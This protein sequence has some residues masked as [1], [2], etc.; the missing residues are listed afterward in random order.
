MRDPPAEPA[1]AARADAVPAAVGAGAGARAASLSEAEPDVEA[2]VW[3]A[4]DAVTRLFATHYRQLVR[5][6]TLLLHDRAV[7]EEVTQD[8]YV[9]LHTSWRRLRDSDKAL[10]YLRA[11]VVNRSRSALRR[12]SVAD[13]YAAS[14][15][16]PATAPSAEAGALGSLEHQQVIA[17]LRQLPTRQRE[18]IV[19]RYYADLSEAEI[20]DA[21]G[22]SRGAVKSHASRGM[23]ALR[24]SL[25]RPS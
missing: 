12:R 6:A 24:K 13:R 17:A 1:D 19:L 5:L 10:A 23:S 14:T 18:V 7:A 15:P 25:E 8:A 16:P 21:I 9:A 4:D 11:S 2:R 22:V 3:T 20:A